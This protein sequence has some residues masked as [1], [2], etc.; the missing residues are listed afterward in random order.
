MRSVEGRVP[1]NAIVSHDLFEGVLGRTALATDIVLYE[2]YPQSY[3][4]HARRLHRWLRGDWQLVPWLFPRVPSGHG[5]RI[6]NPLVLIDRWKIADNLRRSLASATLLLLLVS[7]W[8]WLPGRPLA[9]TLAALAVLAVPVLPALSGDSRRRVEAASRYLLAL[10]FLAHGAALAV[11]AMTRVLVRLSITRRRLLEWTSADHTAAQLRARSSRAVLW[12]EMYASPLLAAGIAALVACVRPSALVV[13][14]P[15]LALWMLAPEIAL[16]VSRPIKVRRELLRGADGAGTAARRRRAPD[17]ALLRDVRGTG[18][19][20]LPVDNYQAEPRE[21][22]AHRTSPTNIGMMLL[23][24]LSAYDFG[25][26]GPT[27]LA[28]RLRNALDTV[29]RLTHYQGHLLNWYETKNLQPLLPR[30]VSTVDS[31]NFA[32]CLLALAEGCRGVASAPVVR[33]EIWAGLTDTLDALSEAMGPTAAPSTGGLGRVVAQIRMALERGRDQPEEAYAAIRLLCEST[34][35]DLDRELIALLETGAYRYESEP[36]HALRTWTDGFHQQLQQVRRELDTL[37]PW[38]ALEGE[39]AA[40]AAELPAALGLHEIPGACARATR[41]ASRRGRPSGDRAWRA[42]PRARGFGATGCARRFSTRRPWQTPRP[43]TT[44]CWQLA[45][46]A[47]AEAA[48]RGMG[49]PSP[50]RPR[51]ET[52]SHRLQRHG[53]SSRLAPLRPPGIGSAPRELRR[54]RQA[55]RARVALVRARSSDDPHRRRSGAPV[56]GRDDVRV[57]H[58]VPLDAKR[59]R[60]LLLARDPA[61]S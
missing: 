2:G 48:V 25:Y 60:G 11:D 40:P 54:H 30:Y 3:A 53:R 41:R 5:G 37:L 39:P 38:Y 52:L 28:L 17:V 49:F 12:R 13:A 16:W 31:G 19:Q 18:D 32:G 24:T 35:A 57:P 23:S 50:L 58:A 8:T 29:R 47:T 51:A 9:W 46:R 61:R 59:C 22:I 1:E 26:L 21:Q 56:L 4:A 27:E 14:A 33:A 44:I 10:A 42:H 55:R 36:L 20:W 15:F 43:C 7:A 34:S 45:G 6:R